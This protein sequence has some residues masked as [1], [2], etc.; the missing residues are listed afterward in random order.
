MSIGPDAWARRRDEATRLVPIPVI[1]RAV[2]DRRLKGGWTVTIFGSG[3]VPL[4]SPLVVTV[5]GVRLLDMTFGEGQVIGRLRNLP[6]GRDL[7]VVRGSSAARGQLRIR[8]RIPRLSA[9][10]YFL[11]RLIHRESRAPASST[12]RS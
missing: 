4:G 8:R 10:S 5:D 3:L 2:A 9:P 6:A 11:R 12:R 1:T 7:V